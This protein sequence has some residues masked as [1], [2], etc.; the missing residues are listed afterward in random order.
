MRA[1]THPTAH[2]K[3]GE[4]NLARFG[5]SYYRLLTL[6]GSR[7]PCHRLRILL[8]G[9]LGAQGQCR[10]YTKGLQKSSIPVHD[11][12]GRGAGPQ[13]RTA[14]PCVGTESEL[15]TLQPRQ[16]RPPMLPLVVS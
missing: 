15:L 6:A 2:N 7:I 11:A 1:S 13:G 10:P 4:E 5:E 9:I 14:R 16:L 8:P 12:A 3:R